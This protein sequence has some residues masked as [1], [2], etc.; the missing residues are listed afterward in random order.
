MSF[1]FLATGCLF[2]ATVRTDPNVGEMNDLNRRGSGPLTSTPRGNRKNA[3]HHTPQTHVGGRAP[4]TP[5]THFG[6]TSITQVKVSEIVPAH[7]ASDDFLYRKSNLAHTRMTSSD[8][9]STVSHPTEQ[10]AIR[11]PSPTLSELVTNRV[12][13]TDA[14]GLK[15]GESKT[16]APG[17]RGCQRKIKQK[18]RSRHR[19]GRVKEV[20]QYV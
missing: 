7:F 4:V 17:T 19:G 1:Y 10:A 15:Q 11:P 20:A 16:S 3:E 13:N 6:P 2:S 8:R 5:Q 14:G 18:Y 9:D 12:A